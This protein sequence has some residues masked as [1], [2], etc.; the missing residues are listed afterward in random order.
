MKIVALIGESG[1]GKS[2]KAIM[3]A[4]E[5]GIEYIID[6]GLLIKGTKVLSGKSAKREDTIV[7]AIKR[8]LFMDKNHRMEIKEVIKSLKPEAILILGTSDRMVDK[9]VE[10]LELP[11]ITERIYIED[12]SNEYEIDLAKKQRRLEGKHVIPV[13]TFEIKKD[14]SG[15]FIDTL[16]VFFRKTDDDRQYFEKTVVRPTFSYL[17]KYT[18]SR[19]VIRDLVKYAAYKVI[20]IS[21]VSNV[22][23]K[24]KEQGIVISLDVEI[25]YGNPIKPLM[26]R[27]QE[28][29]ID[30]VEYMT[31]LNI[32]S[33][34]VNVKK[35]IKI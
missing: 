34:D 22:D 10:I 23:I 24:T 1:T 5:L 18:I 15:Y 17:G 6:D 30:E 19:N 14:F 27:M 12:I 35:M 11:E 21:G 29:I 9:I 31:S 2:Y 33:V 32:L 8:A 3:L 7:S 4:K 13:P 26:R 20:G 25:V 16:K 28:Q